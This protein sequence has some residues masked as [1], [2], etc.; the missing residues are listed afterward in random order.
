VAPVRAIESQA[1]RRILFSALTSAL[2]LR[3]QRIW[4]RAIRAHRCWI[5]HV[6]E[7]PEAE[8]QVLLKDSELE[9]FRRPSWQ[10]IARLACTRYAPG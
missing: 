2:T 10:Q 6:F 3:R 8:P 4:S 9:A 5:D 7:T 1:V